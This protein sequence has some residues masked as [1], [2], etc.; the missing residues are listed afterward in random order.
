MYHIRRKSVESIEVD[1]N[2]Y[3]LSRISV[4]STEDD[5][6]LYHLG[7][8]KRGKYK[9]VSLH[10]NKK[11]KKYLIQSEPVCNKIVVMICAQLFA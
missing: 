1:T 5:T 6:N 4:N 2:L 8:L 9:S 3:H 10:K 11:N 7:R